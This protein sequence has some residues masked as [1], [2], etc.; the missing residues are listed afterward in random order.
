MVMAVRSQEIRGQM[1]CWGAWQ[2][3]FSGWIRSTEGEIRILT[4]VAL[5]GH[6]ASESHFL[7]L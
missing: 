6:L 7:T 4:E 5:L 3:S 2:Q 1:K